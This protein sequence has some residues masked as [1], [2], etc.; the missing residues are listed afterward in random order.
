MKE[1]MLNKFNHYSESF[2]SSIGLVGLTIIIFI[3]FFILNIF[4]GPDKNAEKK[5]AEKKVILEK[6]N[7][8]IETLPRGV[9]TVY[10][11]N[12]GKKLSADEACSS[13]FLER[14]LLN[15]SQFE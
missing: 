8:L 5:I 7:E 2:K 9:L 10:K 6:A 15:L 13:I 4:Y 12:K 1:I 11:S 3:T 14:Y